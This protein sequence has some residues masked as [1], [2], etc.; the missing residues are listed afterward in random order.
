MP[1]KIT[2]LKD[3]GESINSNIVS[4]FM[5]PESGKRYIITTENAVDPHGLTVLHV[6]EIQGN[7]LVKIATDEEWSLI[8]TVMRA[9]ISSSVGSYQYLPS[10]NQASA[11]GQYSRDISVSEPASKTM[12]ESY[13]TGEKFDPDAVV[14][15]PTLEP[16][17][18]S[19]FP[20]APVMQNEDEVVPGIAV[21]EA[22][23][24]IEATP[25]SVDENASPAIQ[26]IIQPEAAQAVEPEVVAQPEEEVQ[27]EEEAQPEEEIQQVITEPV[28]EEIVEQAP[29]EVPVIE[30][31]PSEVNY[32][33]PT[34]SPVVSE[35]PVEVTVPEKTENYVDEQQPVAS[36]YV[37]EPM[38]VNQDDA[39]QP[40]YEPVEV[41][42]PEL[43]QYAPEQQVVGEYP[44][45]NVE[46]EQYGPTPVEA[47]VVDVEQPVYDPNSE[48]QPVQE[49]TIENPEVSYE[50]V[51]PIVENPDGEI[52]TLNPNA[53]PQAPVAV[54]A[55]DMGPMGEAVVNPIL[56]TA[57]P[58]VAAI[59]SE[60]QQLANMSVNNMGM[61]VPNMMNQMPQQNPEMMVN[62]AEGMMPNMMPM[63]PG[64]E[65]MMAGGQVANVAVANNPQPMAMPQNPVVNQ[66]PAEQTPLQ[67]LGINLNFDSQPDLS[68]RATL[69]EVVA[70]AQELF[71]E[72]VKNLVMV[73]TER[74][75]RDLKSR[76]EDLKRREVI[77]AQREQAINDQTMNMLN[78]GYNQAMVRQPMM[79]QPMYQQPMM[80][81]V[82]PQVQQPMQQA[83]YQQPMMQQPVQQPMQ[84]QM[85]QQPMMQQAS[86]QVQQ[87][88]QQTA[89]HVNNNQ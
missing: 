68:A 5:I 45:E 65:N 80:Q 69:D 87:P 31:E 33:E 28:A 22:P 29:V 19:I 25:A 51:Q 9:I 63:A 20:T 56:N 37:Q 16:S 72:G 3:G 52:N 79:Q 70:G 71:Q 76:E 75:Y 77:V 23:V 73:M 83:M 64:M 1:E 18:D 66:Q 30:N 46:M 85:Y 48:V 36:D 40:V 7:N 62:P 74:V 60:M 88:M 4:I 89:M 59:P 11:S 35:A 8:K 2:I 34:V 53:I 38:E 24:T 49:A 42:Q 84:Q 15:E 55:Q 27:P 13:A 39:E 54:P 17:V 57:V 10:F 61:Q 86:P 78:T 41:S 43:E 21:E 82:S 14:P 32:E 47:N 81:Q 6:S 12:I 50:Q 67:K 58:N 26:P 44:T